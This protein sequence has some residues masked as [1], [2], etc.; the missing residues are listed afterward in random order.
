VTY[1]G[2]PLYYFSGDQSAGQT[3]GEGSNGFGAEWYLVTPKGST[4]E[5]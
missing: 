4:L 5:G 3:N 1:N 2:H